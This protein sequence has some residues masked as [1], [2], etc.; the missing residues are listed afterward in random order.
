MSSIPTLSGI[1]SQMIR[2]PR[3][4]MHVLSCGPAGGTPVLFIH[5][6]GASATFWEETMLALPRR[7]A[8]ACA[9]AGVR[10]IIHVSALGV[11]P[12]AP[13]NYLR[14]KT[15]GEEALRASGLDLTILRPSVIFG[16]GDRFLNLFASLQALA[17]LVPL[18]GASSTYQPVW[19]EDVASAV[20]KCLDTPQTIG[21][22]IECAGPKVYTLAELVQLAGRASG[23]A[24]P[25]LPLPGFVARLQARLMELAPGEPLM[26]RDNL[27]S[28]KTPNVASGSLPGLASL[29]IEPAA[30]EAIAPGHLGRQQ[31]T[32]RLE[33]WRAGR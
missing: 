17:P 32:A 33:R 7:L 29:G 13:S 11:G 26:S 10:R 2:T 21:Q 8:A 1:T 12:N 24:R 15:A 23:H 20:V 31:G 30:L 27:D 3:L 16:A 9:A 18:A 5:G 14:S 6:N 22:V 28:M 19:V 4:A 25:V